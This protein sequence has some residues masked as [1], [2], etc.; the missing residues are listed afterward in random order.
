M[1]TPEQCV[2]C[3]YK[4]TIR[5]EARCAKR[6]MQFCAHEKG[7]QTLQMVP[8]ICAVLN[9][10]NNCADYRRRNFHRLRTA[11]ETNRWLCFLTVVV[12]AV[13]IVM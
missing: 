4:R 8:G 5:G 11:L 10:E 9:P 3:R 6:M 1:D 2:T 13:L 12:F 7:L